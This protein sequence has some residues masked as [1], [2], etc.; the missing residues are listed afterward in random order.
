MD[1]GHWASKRGIHGRQASP[2]KSSSGGGLWG[3]RGLRSWGQGGIWDNEGNLAR[4]PSQYSSASSNNP[5][6]CS[7]S[8]FTS[9]LRF[10]ANINTRR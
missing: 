3:P 5:L 4:H 1:T 2:S 6:S 10:G 8:S 7:R 9:L